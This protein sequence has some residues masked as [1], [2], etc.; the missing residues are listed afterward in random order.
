MD[1]YGLKT[2]GVGVDH[3]PI[4]GLSTHGDFF[5]TAEFAEFANIRACKVGDRLAQDR[6]GSATAQYRGKTKGGQDH[7]EGCESHEEWAA[8]TRTLWRLGGTPRRLGCLRFWRFLVSCACLFAGRS[9]GDLG[10]NP[11]EKPVTLSGR[12][13]T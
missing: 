3:H 9:G 11:V 5:A 2:G 8:P 1:I 12:G 7:Q 6:A 4:A 13:W 10:H